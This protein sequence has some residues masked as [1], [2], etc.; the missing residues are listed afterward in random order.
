MISN[1]TLIFRSLIQKDIEEILEM[2]NNLSRKNKEFFHP[3][4]FNIE[5]LIDNLNSNDH[6][7]VLILE[8]KII[9]YSFLRL[10]GYKIPSFGCC[11]RKGYENK[12]YGALLTRWTINKAKDFG[13]SKVI[14]KTYKENTSAQKIYKKIG[15]KIIGETEDKEQYQMILKL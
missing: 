1:D 4:K 3:H 14:L 10:F 12:G 5:T 6:Y 8:N 11:I 9:G 15:F 2:L 7:F 13:Y